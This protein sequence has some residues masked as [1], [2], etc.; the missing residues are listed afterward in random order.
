M[1]IWSKYMKIKVDNEN[2]LYNS[3]DEFGKTLSEDLISYINNK[4]EISP[5]NEKESIEIISS[6]KIDEDKFKK[7]F[8]NY[9]DEQLILINK[10]QKIIKI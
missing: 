5:I 4:Y 1:N 10:Q 7:S 8:E 2:M 3:F 9:C 6:K